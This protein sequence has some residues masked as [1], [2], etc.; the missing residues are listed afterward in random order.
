MLYEICEDRRKLILQF[1]SART[2]FNNYI[3]E[4]DKEKIISGMFHWHDIQ[5]TK[6]QNQYSILPLFYHFTIIQN[7]IYNF[8]FV[9]TFV[10]D[11]FV[12]GCIISFLIHF[13]IVICMI[14]SLYMSIRN[15]AFDFVYQLFD[16]MLMWIVN[17]SFA[18]FFFWEVGMYIRKGKIKIKI[19]NI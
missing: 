14:S 10:C 9:K 11:I 17:D 18:I 3:S 16:E 15:V 12:I 8:L 5:K 4:S 19:K 13:L 7:F 1:L 6:K 2:N